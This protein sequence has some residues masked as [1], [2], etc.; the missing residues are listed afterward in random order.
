MGNEFIIK[1]GFISKSGSTIY[2]NLTVDG[3][4]YLTNIQTGLTTNN[5]LVITSG[6]TVSYRS[7]LSLQGATGPQGET[8][9]Q[10]PQGEPGVPGQDG[11][12]AYEVA[13]AAGYVGTQE[14]WL[15]SLVGPQGEPGETQDLSSYTQS[16]GS[17]KHIVAITQEAF[18]AL[19]EKDPQTIYFIKQA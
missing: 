6:G 7:D 4:L 12:S 9:A 14:E 11:P 8:G 5:I 17:I 19:L 2:E 1:N 15:L 16:D 18:D 13:V 3:D 10:G